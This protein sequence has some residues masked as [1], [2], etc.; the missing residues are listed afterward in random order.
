MINE[1]MIGYMLD[2]VEKIPGKRESYTPRQAV[3]RIAPQIFAKMRRGVDATTIYLELQFLLG[4][5]FGMFLKYLRECFDERVHAKEIWDLLQSAGGGSRQGN[6]LPAGAGSGSGGGRRAEGG[7]AGSRLG[8]EAPAAGGAAEVVHGAD[9]RIGRAAEAEILAQGGSAEGSVSGGEDATPEGGAGCCADGDVPSEGSP[10]DEEL[11]GPEP[12]AGAEAAH[13][14]GGIGSP[15]GAAEQGGSAEGSV[16]GGE[17]IAPE[18]GAGAGAV[19]GREAASG[20]A[21]G[22][23]CR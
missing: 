6:A 7:A 12:D 10:E 21:R 22:R 17:C 5:S 8:G 11:A 2:R 9:D 19:H 15:V 1:K 13:G 16:S 18:G 4:C 14:A 23:G 20:A 3:H